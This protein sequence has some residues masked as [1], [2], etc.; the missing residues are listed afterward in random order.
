MRTIGATM[1]FS[2]TSDLE[3]TWQQELSK[4]NLDK[5]SPYV[6]CLDPSA[7]DAILKTLKTALSVEQPEDLREN[8]YNVFD[9]LLVN[10]STAIAV[11][12][13]V[14]IEYAKS[15]G[16]IESKETQRL[17]A[18]LVRVFGFALLGQ[19]VNSGMYENDTMRYKLISI[20]PCRL[21]YLRKDAFMEILSREVMEK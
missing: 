11:V 3:F 14:A 17:C 13:N 18:D 9:R 12:Q 16:N 6:L 15:L 20:E 21:V 4:L 8:L 5:S 19:L 1:N 2:A 7:A 10:Q